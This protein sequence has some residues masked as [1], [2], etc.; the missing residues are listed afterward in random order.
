M[1]HQSTINFIRFTF[2][3]LSLFAIY[4]IFI[5]SIK[6]GFFQHVTEGKVTGKLSRSPDADAR[7]LE[8][9]IG[10]AALD[11]IAKV[12]VLCFWPVVNGE[13]P[14]LSLLGVPA[15]A[16]MGV[17]YL[18]LALEARRT[19]SLISVA[20]RLA[21]VGLLQTI[22]SQAIVL[23]AY[24]AIAFS[25]SKKA[26]G[27]RPIPHVMTSLILCIYTGMALVALPS[28]TVIPYGLKQ[29]VVAFM[30]P[31]AFW[32]FVMVSMA[33]YLF[34]IE[35][36]KANNRRTI[37]IFALVIAAATHL[38]ALLTS[39]L[40][41]DLGPADVFLPPLP[42][43]VTW[44]PGLTEG[45]ASFLQWDHLIASVTLLLWAVAVYLRDC[46]EHVDSWRFGLEICGLSVIISPVGAA[47]LLI[48]R[49]DEMLCRGEIAKEE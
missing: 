7:L 4:T 33:S 30:V 23:P 45:M 28:P 11:N 8:S 19:R 43:S 39:L 40:H 15:V 9:F 49:L 34:P 37:Y 46:D 17:S 48:W 25:S 5:T 2:I 20:W 12:L 36:E 32:L 24:C 14:S 13:N 3:I 22:Y 44:F 16:S 1:S 38:G 26:N 42:W 18:L 47:V 35:V 21:W 29:A 41:A 6:K 10:V 31:W 27:F